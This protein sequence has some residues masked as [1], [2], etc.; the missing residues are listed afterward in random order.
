MDNAYALVRPPGHHAVAAEG[1]GFCIFGNVAIAVKHAVEERGLSRI[2]VVDWDVHHGNGT[3]S[4]F[5]SDPGVLTVSLHQQDAFPPGSGR[6]E[7]AG[8]GEGS[9]YNINVPLPPG[10]D[11]GAYESAFERVVIPALHRFHPELIVVASGLDAAAMDPLARQ[12]MHSEGYRNLTR[13]IMEVANETCDGRLVAAHE[14][15]YSSFLVPFCGLAIVE[16]LS[17]EKTA[18]EDPYLPLIADMGGQGLQPH[19]AR[20]I[21]AVEPLLQKL[22][23]ETAAG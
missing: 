16:T 9:G 17:G 18:V 22:G 23:A 1:M 2:A 7:E 11:V 5:Y 3:Q 19:Q 20:A 21:D 13:M 14:G 15:G 8:E 6:V 12:M 10:S 4:A